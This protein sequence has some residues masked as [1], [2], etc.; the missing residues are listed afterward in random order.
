MRDH[1]E[2]KHFKRRLINT[3][4]LDGRSMSEVQRLP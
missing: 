2:P 1:A 4:D 3:R